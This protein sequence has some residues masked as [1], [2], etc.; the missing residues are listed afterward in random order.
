MGKHNDMIEKLA[1]RL[2]MGEISEA[3]YNTAMSALKGTP[4]EAVESVVNATDTV[5]AEQASDGGLGGFQDILEYLKANAG[6]SF[7]RSEI[8]ENTGISAEG[9]NTIRPVLTETRGVQTTGHKKSTKY[10]WGVPDAKAAVKEKAAKT[11]ERATAR[12]VNLP[13]Q[14]KNSCL[15]ADVRL[16]TEAQVK[17]ECKRMDYKPSAI[18]DAVRLHGRFPTKH[19][20][21]VQNAMR[22]AGAI[23]AVKRTIEQSPRTVEGVLRSGSS[24]VKAFLTATWDNRAKAGGERPW[25]PCWTE[26]ELALNQMALAWGKMAAVK[27]EIE[28]PE[29]GANPFLS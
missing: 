5:V 23:F 20:E 26:A 10:S 18:L 1:V 14:D 6:E 12:A 8:L 4:Q 28:A 16:T 7:S 17:A 13:T 9:W 22:K 25:E 11:A 3:G 21:T 29:N 27:A 19:R 15:P 2:A 24:G